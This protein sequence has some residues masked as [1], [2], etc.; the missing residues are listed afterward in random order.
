MEFL[1]VKVTLR[2]VVSLA[3][4]RKL[5]NKKF[6][7]ANLYKKGHDNVRYSRR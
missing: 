1:K 2:N 6:G 5:A 7:L 4:V 3:K